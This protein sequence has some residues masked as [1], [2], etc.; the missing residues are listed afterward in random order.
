VEP[1]AVATERRAL[2]KSQGRSFREEILFHEQS[3]GARPWCVQDKFSSKRH[4]DVTLDFELMNGRKKA[5]LEGYFE[6]G[7]YAIKYDIVD[8]PV[9]VGGPMKK[10][11]A[12]AATHTGFTVPKDLLK[13]QGPRTHPDRSLFRASPATHSRITH[14]QDF[15]QDMDRP[16][17]MKAQEVY[18]DEAD[19]EASAE[20][21]ERRLTYDPSSADRA[22]IPRQDH[23]PTMSRTLSR[24]NCRGSRLLESDKA[25]LT[26]MGRTDPEPAS[27]MGVAVEAMEKP[28]RTRPDKVVI[29][30]EHYSSRY[31]SSGGTNISAL[32]GPRSKL[33]PDFARPSRRGFMNKLPVD[34]PVATE[35]SRAS[36]AQ[37]ALPD[38]CTE[39][40]DEAEAAAP[41]F[42]DSSRASSMLTDL[43]TT[44][45]I[46]EEDP[47]RLRASMAAAPFE[48]VGAAVAH[49][50]EEEA[51]RWRPPRT[52]SSTARSFAL[53]SSGMG[54]ALSG[55]GSQVM[56]EALV[57]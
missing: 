5:S 51:M 27:L 46:E 35:K 22:V 3:I 23:C 42:I 41:P 55:V 43:Q 24:G 33:P 53:N 13:P 28:S 26:S 44:Q 19:P 4:K 49:H 14:V 11:L 12:R 25:L 15:G 48:A 39:L 45:R 16:P 34:R 52:Q 6:P 54:Q 17:L 30:F 9:K 38:W 31:P 36:E 8:S 40:F 57:T 7:K 18:Y 56:R 1:H 50:A 20:W 10:A 37:E 21:L 32:R 29:P 2:E 47:A